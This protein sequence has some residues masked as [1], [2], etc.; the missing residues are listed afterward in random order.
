MTSWSSTRSI[1][2][3]TSVLTSMSWIATLGGCGNAPFLFASIRQNQNV[4]QVT[5]WVPAGSRC[6]P[7]EDRATGTTAVR[8]GLPGPTSHHRRSWSIEIRR[9]P[10]MAT[11]AACAGE[12]RKHEGTTPSNWVGPIFRTRYGSSTRSSIGLVGPPCCT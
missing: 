6:G 8:P 1:W 2:H 5:Q 3:R 9:P 12:L 4:D 10:P 7:R 11:S